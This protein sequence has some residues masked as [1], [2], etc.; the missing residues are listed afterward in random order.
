MMSTCT[1]FSRKTAEEGLSRARLRG[2]SAHE[3]LIRERQRRRQRSVAEAVARPK[4][5]DGARPLRQHGD[6][7]A[8]L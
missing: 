3:H 4:V 6:A 2:G 7:T 8:R 5:A 1:Q